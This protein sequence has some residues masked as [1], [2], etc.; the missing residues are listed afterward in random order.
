MRS[1]R[2]IVEQIKYVQEKIDKDPVYSPALRANKKER[3]ALI[4]V[5]S[6]GDEIPTIENILKDILFE[7]KKLTSN[8]KQ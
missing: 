4:W 2:E 3:D 8:E 6:K 7:L 1:E 5:I